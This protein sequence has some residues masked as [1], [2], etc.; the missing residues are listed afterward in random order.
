MP[1]PLQVTPQWPGDDRDSNRLEVDTHDTYH[2]REG[3]L[4]SSP[5]RDLRTYVRATCSLPAHDARREPV[6]VVEQFLRHRDREFLFNPD[7]RALRRRI[8][9]RHQNIRHIG[10]EAHRLE[11]LIVLGKDAAGG[12]TAIYE[13]LV[14]RILA[15]PLSWAPRH[16]IDRANFARLKT[17]LRTGRVP[18]R[19]GARLLQRI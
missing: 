2:T 10:K 1:I 15:L 17:K 8:L 13:E 3:L 18:K 4:G 11:A 5:V 12:G 6:P 7:G 16:G 9:V 14:A 19:H